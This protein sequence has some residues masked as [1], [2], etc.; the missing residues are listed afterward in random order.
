MAGTIAGALAGS[1]RALRP[2]AHGL[3]AASDWILGGVRKA[4][5]VLP[6]HDWVPGDLHPCA[7]RRARARGLRPHVAQPRYR[8]DHLVRGMMLLVRAM[9]RRTWPQIWKY[10]ATVY[11][12]G[13][14]TGGWYDTLPVNLISAERDL[15]LRPQVARA[16]IVLGTVLNKN[17]ATMAVSCWLPSRRAHSSIAHHA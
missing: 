11:V 7:V 6:D 9:T 16:S 3:L 1:V 13:F 17:V 2:G 5:L 14:G 15:G 10:F 8:G 4:A 12:T